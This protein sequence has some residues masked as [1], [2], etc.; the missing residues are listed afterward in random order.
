MSFAGKDQK[1][2]V[3][4]LRIDKTVFFT[5]PTAVGFAVFQNLW[6]TDA[7][8]HAVSADISD[9]IIDPFEK[10]SVF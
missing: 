9:E 6:L 10:S 8:C 1:I 5:D 3:F 2:T 4:I 7:F